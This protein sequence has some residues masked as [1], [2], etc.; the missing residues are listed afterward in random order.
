[1]EIEI[2]QLTRKEK[3]GVVRESYEARGLDGSSRW[4]VALDLGGMSPS[5]FREEA[6]WAEAGVAAIGGKSVVLLLELSSG[7]E[8][9]RI[10]VPSYFGH[11]SVQLVDGVEWLFVLGWADVHA[12]APNLEE[13]WVS[14]GVA[15]DGITGGTVEG[16]ILHVNA[17]MDPPG[18]WFSVQ[19]D[20]RTG[21]E[22][23]REPAFTDDYAGIYGVGKKSGPAR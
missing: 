13:Q 22:L 2:V 7:A 4:K 5:P 23:A 11:L 21:R 6:I 20:V 14:R 19:L 9:R 10:S 17:E 18:G 15:V 3:R 8:R 16:D 12:F 1:M